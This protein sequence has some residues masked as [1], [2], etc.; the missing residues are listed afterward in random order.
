[1]PISATVGVLYLCQML[2]GWLVTDTHYT[3]VPLL[4]FP[5]GL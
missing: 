5:V 4:L 2:L 3:T 1:V